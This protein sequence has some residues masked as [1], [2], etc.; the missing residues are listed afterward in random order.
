MNI[1]KIFVFLFFDNEKN[2]YPSYLENLKKIN[3]ILLHD[4]LFVIGCHDN[5]LHHVALKKIF[6]VGGHILSSDRFV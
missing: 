6:K 4:I 5:R 1:W 3:K 2:I